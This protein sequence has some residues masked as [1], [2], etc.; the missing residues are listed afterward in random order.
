MGRAP[1]RSAVFTPYAEEVIKH[2]A[3]Q[4]AR[5]TDM[6][7]SDEDD[8]AQEMR[9]HLLSR[10]HLFDRKRSCYST[11][12]ARVIDSCFASLLRER[13]RQ[14]RAPARD[15]VSLEGSRVVTGG[16]NTTLREALSAE[17]VRGRDDESPDDEIT[18]QEV[19][20]AVARVISALPPLLRDICTRLPD[21]SDAA[22]KRELGLSRR[23]FDGAMARIRQTFADARLGISADTSAQNGV[24]NERR[25]RGLDPTESGE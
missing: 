21:Q 17:C 12:V 8:F 15:A 5:R 22:I 18:R 24:R 20:A 1:A 7:R 4:L 3:R 16:V 13:R 25:P 23:Q 2:K 10:F 6:C 19:I 14:K 11:F 9:R